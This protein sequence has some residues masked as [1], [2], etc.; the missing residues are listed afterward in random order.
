MLITSNSIN[1]KRLIY[2][3]EHQCIM[4]TTIS[5]F[6]FQNDESIKWEENQRRLTRLTNN[7]W[8]PELFKHSIPTKLTSK[9]YVTINL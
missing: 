3:I 4:L 5:G 7:E 2:T 9:D 1:I 8:E 6:K